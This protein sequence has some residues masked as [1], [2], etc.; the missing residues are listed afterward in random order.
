MTGEINNKRKMIGVGRRQ[1]CGFASLHRQRELG[2]MR[3]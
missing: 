2:S 1:S 3:T